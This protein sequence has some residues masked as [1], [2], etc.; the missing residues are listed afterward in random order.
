MKTKDVSLYCFMYPCIYYALKRTGRNERLIEKILSF[1]KNNITKKT[2]LKKGDILIWKRNEDSYCE[3]LSIICK[4]VIDICVCYDTHV[5]VYEGK[6]VVSDFTFGE[7]TGRIR[8][9]K[10]KDLKNPDFFYR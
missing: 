9:R 7:K 2:K 8:I 10:L 1:N 5:G 3:P 6:G 4:K